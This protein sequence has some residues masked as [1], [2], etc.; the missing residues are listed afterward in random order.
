M[1]F[2]NCTHEP[3]LYYKINSG[4]NITL[5]LRQVDDFLVANKDDAECNRIGELIQSKMTFPLNTLGL[6]RKFNGV[7]VEQTRNYN[8]VHCATYINKIVKHHGWE[9][10]T[11]RTNPTPMRADNNYQRE[12]QETKGPTDPKEQAAL[13][14]KMGFNYRQAIG[15]LTYA[16]TICHVDIS[17]AIITLSQHVQHPAEIHYDA[18]KDLFTYL[19]STRDYGLVYWRPKPRM[20]LPYQPDPKTISPPSALAKFDNYW[21]PNQLTGC[22]DSTW[23]SN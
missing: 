9:N 1:G 21:N 23:A 11:T 6:V 2:K 14:K 12:I 3:C 17:I 18:V 19:H 10:E 5:I 20:D 15:E 8:K 13:Q 4:E 16:Y 22:C 7:D